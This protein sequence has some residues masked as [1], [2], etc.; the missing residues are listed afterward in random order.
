[1]KHT[2]TTSEIVDMIKTAVLFIGIGFMFML[3]LF[4]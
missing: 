2:F 1:M 3:M 4:L